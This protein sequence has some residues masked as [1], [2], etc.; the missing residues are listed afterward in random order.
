MKTIKNVE[1]TH[2]H[3]QQQTH[4]PTDTGIQSHLPKIYKETANSSNAYHVQNLYKQ[5]PIL[6]C[7]QRICSEKHMLLCN[8]RNCS[9]RLQISS[10]Q[11]PLPSMR[12]IEFPYECNNKTKTN[13]AL[14]C[15]MH[16]GS[17]QNHQKH[18]N[19]PLQPVPLHLEPSYYYGRAHRHQSSSLSTTFTTM[20]QHTIRLHHENPQIVMKSR[21]EPRSK[22][23][24]RERR[25]F[26]LKEEDPRRSL[27][28][29]FHHFSAFMKA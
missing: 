13:L 14:H 5:N 28:T 20:F 15:K 24:T 18:A 6:L 12:K 8:R 16:H 26:N 10:Y 9:Q 11:C 22:Q 17:S 29:I 4:K 23:L 27:S 1:P 25:R 21:F 3:T 19:A 7:N 2:T